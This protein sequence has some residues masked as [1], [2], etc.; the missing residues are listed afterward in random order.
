[1]NI[2]SIQSHVAYGHVGN[3]SAAFPLQRLGAEVW[4]VHTVQFSNHTGYGAWR[5]QVFGADLVRDVVTGIEERGVLPK[6]DGVLSGYMG[7]A[8]IGEAV[9]EA[10]AKVKAANPRAQY[11][12]DPVIGD[13]GPGVFVKQGVPEFLAQSAIAHADV[14]TPNHFE[15]E[16]LNGSPI[17]GM[18]GFRAAV[19]ALHARGP[20]IVL[21]TSAHLADT[22][23]DCVDLF[24]SSFEGVFRLRTPRLPEDFN[25]AGDTIAALFFAHCL[26][27]KSPRAALEN[28][29]AAIYGI[30]QRTHAEGRRELMLIEAQDEIVAPTTTFV[31]EPV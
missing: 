13:A 11:C 2:L 8:A 5:G 31:A 9:L 25:G 4:P 29:G 16:W 14:L 21:V 17:V 3:A 18:T 26:A 12:C 23:D 24:V 15:L 19:D 1:M 6:C 30:L 28:A 7:D 10:V 27:T 20:K 22:P